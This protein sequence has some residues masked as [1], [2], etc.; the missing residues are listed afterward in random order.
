M[1]IQVKVKLNHSD[2]FEIL[3]NILVDFPPQVLLGRPGL[4]Q[5]VLDIV[6]STHCLDDI[7]LLAP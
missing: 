1:N 3:R 5:S 4:I 6:G 2:S 7:G